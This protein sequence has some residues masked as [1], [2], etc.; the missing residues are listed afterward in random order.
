MTNSVSDAL[1]QQAGIGKDPLAV[2][3]AMMDQGQTDAARQIL[4]D[5][6]RQSPN[7]ADAWFSLGQVK[8]RQSDFRDAAKAFRR[9]IQLAPHVAD[10]YVHLGNT[11]LRDGRPSQAIDV[12]RDGLQRQPGS[13]LLQFNLGVALRQVDDIDG[14]IVQFKRAIALFP[15][16]FQAYFSLGNAYRDKKMRAEAEA[17]YR[18]AVTIEPRFA[19]GYA[20]LA[21]LLA[22]YEDYQGAITV[23]HQ[24][25]GLV[26]DHIH[27][28]R[29]LA[30]CYYRTGRY[31]EGAEVTARGLKVAPD[32][33]MQHYTMGEMLYGLIREGQPDKARTVA[34]WWRQTYPGNPVVQHMGAAILGEKAPDRAD[35][36][37]VRET[38]DRFAGQFE[39]VLAGL[40]YQ[41]PERLCAM[42]REALSGRTGL[43]VLDA[44]C[45][46]GLC[47]PYLK[48]V[49][50]RLV[51][52]DLSG[53]MLEKAKARGLY[54]A[55]HEAE[56]GAFLAGTRDSYDLV[57]AADVFCYFGALDAAFAA[58][59]GRTAG[60]GL[61]GFT[62]EAMQG[63]AP[64]EGYRLGPT[65]RYQHDADYIRR[66]LQ[67]AGYS[68]L[69]WDDTQGREEM[70][71][72]VPCF[73]IL[74][75]RD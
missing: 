30:L 14:A 35:D 58:L 69:R 57:I 12:Y 74:A 59:A 3:G 46:T 16:Y 25:L 48:P 27:A 38:F 44:G 31:A 22:E 5:L 19:D 23:C 21:G 53:G 1:L 39:T 18:K 29:N 68:V 54:D 73:M 65:G 66:V 6:V 37:Y 34:Q 9:A 62:V 7:R 61:F 45:G 20:N 13:P 67:A 28:L 41:V 24:V 40:G 33:T 11:Y 36:A 17:A 42:A 15:D 55:L 4:E 50:R 75:G 26:P 10:G 64:V 56:L 71:Q 47:A 70:G 52:V 49:A 60:G 32:D 2:A 8:A 43:T 72:P 63:P 51:G